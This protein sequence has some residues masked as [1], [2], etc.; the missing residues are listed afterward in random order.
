M[1]TYSKLRSEASAVAFLSLHGYKQCV[2]W[3]DVISVS[4][5]HGEFILRVSRTI[6]L[7]V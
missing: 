4:E 5:D 6:R 3:K 7:A 2:I 1:P